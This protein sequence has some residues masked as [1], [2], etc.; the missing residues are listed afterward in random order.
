ML[1]NLLIAATLIYTWYCCMCRDDEWIWDVPWP[2]PSLLSMA[3]HRELALRSKCHREH[4]LLVCP[5]SQ[6]PPHER[7]R[8]KRMIFFHL[9]LWLHLLENMELALVAPEE[10]RHSLMM[11]VLPLVYLAITD[12]D[13]VRWFLVSR[14]DW[15]MICAGIL[16]MLHNYYIIQPR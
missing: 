10:D 13:D 7:T 8:M 1:C 11:W 3:Q 14:V 6:M 15:S 12:V 9:C 4:S 2:P 5:T 16:W